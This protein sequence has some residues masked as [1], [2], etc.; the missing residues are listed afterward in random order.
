[1]VVAAAGC[2]VPGS[3]EPE[4]LGNAPAVGGPVGLAGSVRLP[5]PDRLISPVEL[6]Q[7]FLK[8]GAA[9]DWD[10]ALRPEDR[11]RAAVTQGKLFLDQAGAAAWK[12]GTSIN[13]VEVIGTPTVTVDN[14]VPVKLRQVGVLDATG[15]LTPAGDPQIREYTFRVDT[16]SMLLTSVPDMLPLSLTGLSELFRVSPVYYW[17]PTDRYLVPDRRY[18]SAGIS[19][20]KRVKTIV[21]RVLAGPS[22]FLSQPAA[23]HVPSVDKAL[24][25][26]TLNGTNVV[27]NLPPMPEK[28]LDRSLNRLA[29]QLR[30]S[31]HPQRYSVELRPG[32]RDGHTFTGTEY[33][34]ANPSQPMDERN[35]R[36]LFG[37][38]NG[39]VIPIDPDVAPPSILS[40]P[41]NSDVV[42]AAVNTRQNS[43]ALVRQV[44]GGP[45]QL[46]VGR[47]PVDR[48][49]AAFIHVAGLDGLVGPYS[50]PSYLPGAGDRVLIVAAGNLYDVD[51]G[52]GAVYAVNLP[53]PLAGALVAVSVAPD[54]VR[55]AMVT[56][57]NVYVATIDPSKPPVTIGAGSARQLRELYVA[58]LIDLRGVA[59][60][61]EHQI[62]VGGR[63]GLMITAID[64]GT[65]TSTGP[66][67]LVGG[68]LTQLSA[69][70]RDPVN[71]LGGG[72]VVIEVASTSAHRQSYVPYS[73]LVAVKAP[74]AS[75]P[76]PA[77]SA[78]ASTPPSDPR[79]TAAFYADV[80]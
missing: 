62:I 67:G 61:Y 49:A 50:R 66:N 29:T 10:P 76:S 34:R 53:S 24:D 70:P 20:E 22:E 52:T 14:S 33:L 36:R 69:V 26:A 31:L 6:V 32:G 42:A 51:L 60:N 39:K 64:G 35:E 3:G 1:V 15:A 40:R 55:I 57:S 16:G 45:R 25:N 37:A 77:P 54:G 72:D 44:G 17:D 43:A 28:D 56:V 30:W 19:D 11:I 80:L 78:S 23:V 7:R 47:T 21:A 48:S 46:W 9:A 8:T 65:L 13:V 12:P 27:V 71:N 75:R 5:E 58:P 4:P 79:V 74:A 59:W 38:V 41:E 2:G 73:Q 68:Q 18:I 63:S